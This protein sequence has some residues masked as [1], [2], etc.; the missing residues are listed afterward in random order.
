[1]NELELLGKNCRDIVSGYEGICT[2]IVE[3]FYGCRQIKLQSRSENGRE[4][5]YPAYFMEKQIEVVDDGISGQVE[6]PEYHKPLYF[7]KECQDKVTGIKGICVGRGIWLFN[8]DQYVLE[9]QPEDASKES[10]IVWLD[11]GRIEAIEKPEK[12]V[13]QE[14]ITGTRPGGMFDPSFYPAFGA[15]TVV[16][17]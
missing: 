7:G 14:E 16:E 5:T 12:E 4:K 13:K 8:C 3:H 1:M 9:I 2:G 15:E 10:R 17:C 6:I 11:D